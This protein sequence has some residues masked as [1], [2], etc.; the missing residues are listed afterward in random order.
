MRQPDTII[1]FPFSL[2]AR[3]PSRTIKARWN[4]DASRYVELSV[5]HWPDRKCVGASVL[6]HLVEDGSVKCLPFSMKQVARVPAGRYSQK[7]LREAFDTVM[8][9]DELPAIVQ[10]FTDNPTAVA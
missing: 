2:H 9:L 4:I 6:D 1:E 5:S 7:M 3:G 8:R 10:E